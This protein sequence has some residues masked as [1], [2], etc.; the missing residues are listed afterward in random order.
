MYKKKVTRLCYLKVKKRWEDISTSVKKKGRTA[1]QNEV[2]RLK[3]TGNGNLPDDQV[4]FTVTQSMF[5]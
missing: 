3:I 4:I 2:K 5:V 1:R